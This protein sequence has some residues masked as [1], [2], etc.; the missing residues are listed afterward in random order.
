MK[1]R[2]LVKDNASNISMDL[3]F[4]SDIHLSC[5]QCTCAVFLFCCHPIRQFLEGCTSK[6]HPNLFELSNYRT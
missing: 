3:P 1:V 2:S 5:R 6:G 4:H